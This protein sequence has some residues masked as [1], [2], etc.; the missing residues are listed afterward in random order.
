MKGLRERLQRRAGLVALAISAVVFGVLSLAHS[1]TAAISIFVPVVKTFVAKGGPIRA[2]DIRW[3][4]EQR[5]HRVSLRQLRGFANTDLFPGELISPQDVGHYAQDV[6]LVAVAPTSAVDE[7][8]AKTGSEVDILL[9]TG[10]QVKW[11]SG[12]VPVVSKSSG[13][14]LPASIDVA[15]PIHEALGFEA[16][17]GRGTIELVGLTS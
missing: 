11:Q 15:M 1:K 13:V 4:P 12:P 5:L 9:K 17:R 3:I 14:G 8:V 6:V 16:L 2:Q 7:A 10:Q